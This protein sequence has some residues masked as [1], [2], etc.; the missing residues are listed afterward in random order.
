LGQ[1]VSE[2]FQKK[3]SSKKC[4]NSKDSFRL[5]NETSQKY[6]TREGTIYM[7]LRT[8]CLKCGVTIPEYNEED[9]V[10]KRALCAKC[11][12]KWLSFNHKYGKEIV[13]KYPNG[14]NGHHATWAVFIREL[15]NLWDKRVAKEEVQF[16]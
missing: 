6:R 4:E 2:S 5:D 8:D 15:P 3:R 14:K 1:N 10:I 7:K 9:D 13:K 16:T 11:H 12:V